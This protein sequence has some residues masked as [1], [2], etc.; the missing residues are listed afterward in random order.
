VSERAA[1][2]L[3][4]VTFEVLRHRLWEIND[5]MGLTVGRVSGSTA[6]Y[7]AGDF[8]TAILTADGQ[9][10]Y[11]GV[12][13]IRQ[14]SALDI[15]V[16]KVLEVFADDIDDGDVFLTSD[17]WYGA[18][19]AMDT[20]VVAPVFA[21][22][23]RVAWTGVVIH[24]LDM[25]GPHPGSW[26]VGARNAYQEVPLIPPVKIVERGRLRR[27]VEAAFLRN[28]RTPDINAL[29]LR[30]KIAAQ[31]GTR[32]RLL[33]IV[34]EYGVEAF[35][36][37]QQQILDYVRRAL[38]T[39]I[40][41]LP[42]GT[43]YASAMLD[44]NGVE[45]RIYRLK[46]ALTKRGE[47]LLFDFTGTDR[48]AEGVI[49][50][51]WSGLIGGILQVAFPLLC[52]D[53]PWSHGA[54]VDCIDI[55]S[56]PGTINNAIFPAGTSMATVNACQ[57]TGN[58]VWEAMAKMY[59]C[60]PEELR[61]E[62]IGLGYGGLNTAVIAGPRPD[63]R[64]FVNL[65]SDSVGGGGARSF[66]DGVDTCSNVIA[67]AYS[68]PN[69][70][71]IE[72]LTPLLYVY[73]RE[74]AE[75]A[76]AGRWRGGVG[77]EYMVMP[78]GAEEPLEAV[79]IGTGVSHMESKGVHGG[80]PGT[81]QRNIVLRGT[82]LAR[83]FAAGAIPLDRAAV[84][85]ASVEVAAAKDVKR[86]HPGDAWLCF[87]M[88]GGGYG[89]PLTRDPERVARDVRRGLV[90]VE[91]AARNYAVVLVGAGTVATGPTAA[92][93]AERRR[94]RLARGRRLGPDWTG[95][96]D[97]GGRSARLQIGEVLEVRDTAAGPVLGCRGCQR[98]FGPAAED[99]RARALLVEHALSALSPLNRYGLEDEVVV[100]A[101]CCPGC[102]AQFSTDVQFRAEDPRLP[103]M[104]LALPPPAHPGP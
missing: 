33:E 10:L 61:R 88:G 99:P 50:C 82:D 9:G 3:D 32:E 60:G 41:S 90:T 19:H 97:F 55:V 23:R 87:C 93:R 15:V 62:V 39:R 78:H 2:R 96:A 101:Y 102:G 44:H 104:H 83:Q 24:E 57:S 59:A 66:A 45:N 70:E 40:A 25:G 65:F 73:R 52:Y 14:A 85:A 27:D 20:A 37:C 80:A 91:E 36:A 79:F 28:S 43:W 71:R 56:E 103:D 17:P 51:A 89:D 54:V 42:D 48:Q 68:I 11:A 12:Y 49:N 95:G 13:V 21:A 92:L 1:G 77:I 38:R 34:R 47:R 5:E 18:L 4:P 6:V 22:G 74:R 63:G 58:L 76:G 46:L 94:E 67:P 81:V 72:S 29:N 26:C 86:L 100:R 75:T 84:A 98:P 7:E 35:L 53:L 16:Q 64:T 30:A 31:A 69:V 8:N